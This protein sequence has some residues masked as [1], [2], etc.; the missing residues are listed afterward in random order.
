MMRVQINVFKCMVN[1]SS[2]D[3]GVYFRDKANLRW[4]SKVKQHGDSGD[5]MNDESGVFME[6]E[7]IVGGDEGW[8]W[9]LAI[10]LD[11]GGWIGELRSLLGRLW[12][13]WIFQVPCHSCTNWMERRITFDL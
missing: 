6:A 3:F 7:C 12:W 11:A 13:Q 10:F 9:M 1:I 5:V 2:Q 8:F 4:W